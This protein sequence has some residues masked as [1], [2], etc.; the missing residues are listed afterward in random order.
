M[1]LDVP[2]VT[3]IHH[4]TSDLVDDDRDPV[5]NASILTLAITSPA[6]SAVTLP[7]FEIH[8][9]DTFGELL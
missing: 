5:L 4:L 9:L 2:D 3:L 1:L 8:Q 6:S 7:N